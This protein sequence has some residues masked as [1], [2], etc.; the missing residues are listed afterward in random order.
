LLV[1]SSNYEDGLATGSV[2]RQYHLGQ[3]TVE[4]TFPGWDVSVGPLAMADVDGDGT[5]DLFV[6]GRVAPGKYP[7]PVASWLFR[8]NGNQFIRD[9]ENCRRL[10][11]GGLVSGAVFSDLDG[12][13]FP[14]LVLA[15]EW[16]PVKVFRN[17]R[18]QL[19]DAT[20]DLGL[21]KYLG[22]WNSVTTG[23]FDGDGKL[24]IVAGNWGRNTTYQ[25][26]RDQPLQIFY[27]EWRMTGTVDQMEA[28]YDR[29]LK[30]VVPCCTFDVARAMPWIA[31]RFPTYTSFGAAS[32]AEILGDRMSGTK[33]LPANWLE[34]TVFLNRG[35]HFEARPLP[36]EAQFAPAFGVSVADLDGDGTEDIFL[37]QNF[38]AVDG[39]TPR[40]D[41][42]RGLWLAGD[43]QGNFR[44]VPGQES[45]IKVYGEQRGCAACDYD[46][47]GRVDLVVTQNGAETKLYHN[48]RAR[49][50]LRVRLNGPAGNP[51]A[52]GASLRLKLGSALGPIREIHAGSGYWSQ[53]SAVQVLGTP[54]APTQ[55]WVR[56]PGGQTT[57]A[58]VPAGAREVAVDPTGQLKVV[59]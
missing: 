23:D 56:W 55:L 5:L 17:E 25:A 9:E 38:F 15:C 57:T 33:V 18:G 1:G 34:T 27:G 6:G 10:A 26:H 28:Y 49:P 46:G 30:K 8:G 43:G 13:G 47:D 3:R 50:G 29:G 20:R 42:G 59:R 44:A 12:D 32:V 58:N 41:A 21:D 52:I 31:E 37:S 7:T 48:A 35:S 36:I 39:D 19:R 22:W 11:Q 40:S 2:V 4:D 51:R 24:D 45:G 14:D 16:G 54:Q 53:D